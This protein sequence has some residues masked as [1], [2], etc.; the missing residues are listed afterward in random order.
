[1]LKLENVPFLFA[2]II[3]TLGWLVTR[4][5]DQAVKAPLVGYRMEEKAEADGKR[6][7]SLRLRNISSVIAF[8]NLNVLLTY[9][10]GQ[11]SRFLKAEIQYEA[12]AH[13]SPERKTAALWDPTWAGVLVSELQPRGAVRLVAEVRGPDRPTVWCDSG[14]DTVRLVEEGWTTWVV[15]HET[16]I[17]LWLALGLVVL[18]VVYVGYLAGNRPRATAVSLAVLLLLAISAAWCAAGTIRVVD[19]S[20]GA[21]VECDIYHEDRDLKRHRAGQTTSE[22]IFHVTEGG[23]AGEKYVTISEKYDPASATCPV[24]NTTLRVKRTAQLQGFVLKGEFLQSAGAPAAAALQY[25]RAAL[26]AQTNRDTPLFN[27]LEF[28]ATALVA[29]AIEVEKPFVNTPT[30]VRASVE[31]REGVLDL[32]RGYGITPTGGLT[33]DTIRQLAV[34]ME[35]GPEKTSSQ[36]RPQ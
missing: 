32:Q 19:A 28:R 13:V 14:T 36:S 26:I 12:P 5:V 10:D 16:E 4:A 34:R 1:M 8:R 18:L 20:T 6:T 33:S 2:L 17:L 30:S 35:D 22:G 23:R 15:M 24:G 25:R 11:G 3:A 31:F 7:V 29:Q 9:L 27:A 21:G